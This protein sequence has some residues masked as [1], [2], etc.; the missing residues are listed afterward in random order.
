MNTVGRNA[1]QN[2]VIAKRI[3]SVHRSEGF[4]KLEK[5][6]AELRR[7]GILIDGDGPR[8]ALRPVARI[9]GGLDR[10]LAERE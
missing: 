9:P 7:Q 10:F 6:L 2:D 3:P 8:S 5:M 4:K 1:R